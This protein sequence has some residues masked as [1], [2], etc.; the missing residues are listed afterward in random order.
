VTDGG[1]V[2]VDGNLANV[3]GGAVSSAVVSVRPTDGV[4][5][6]YPQ[7][8]YFVGTV[9]ESAFAPFEL[10]AQADTATATAVTVQV[11]YTVDGASVTDTATVPL[12]PPE[13]SD[14]GGSL[15]V[16]AVVALLAGL[17]GVAAA[18]VYV[19]RYR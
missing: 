9:E 12:P 10:T 19:T 2:S 3:G 16:G 14:G 15:P 13:S 4:Q 18:T 11:N 6:A 8:N 17:A 1:R 7:R 5:P